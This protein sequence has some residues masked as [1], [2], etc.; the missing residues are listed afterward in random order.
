[1]TKD[2]LRH[3]I[4]DLAHDV[5]AEWWRYQSS[6]AHHVVFAAGAAA[7]RIQPCDV[8]RWERQAQTKMVDV[9][10]GG[11]KSDYEIADRYMELVSA[12]EDDLRVHV[13]DLI[14]SLGFEPWSCD[15]CGQPGVK[16]LGSEGYCHKHR[17]PTGRGEKF[18]LEER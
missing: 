8:E 6:K 12:F 17:P 16:S 18:T 4:A 5:W 15:I 9:P 7:L 10:P 11:E 14:E 2:E 13:S 3:A 1:M